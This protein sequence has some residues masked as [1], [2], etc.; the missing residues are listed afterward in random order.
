ML[1]NDHLMSNAADATAKGFW[2][3]NIESFTVAVVMALIIK[4]FA[5]EAFEVPTESM[6]PT[7]IGRSPGGD[8]L[9]VDKFDG[10]AREPERFE[11]RVFMYPLSQ[12][13]NYVKRLI[14]IG[15]ETV[16]VAHGDIFTGESPA[17]PFHIARKS[18][19]I[20]EAIFHANP[21][22]PRDAWTDFGGGRIWNTW[23]RPAAGAGLN[24][25]GHLRLDAG[26]SEL[27]VGLSKGVTPERKDPAAAT[28][29][30]HADADVRLPQGDLRFH[31]DVTPAAGA[32]SVVLRITDGTQVTTPIR[33]DLAVEGSGGTSRL[34]HG[35]RVIESA[36]LKACQLKPA[37]RQ[38][39][40]LEN[41][42]DRIRVLLDGDEL[43][44]DLYEQSVIPL[45][46]GE[47]LVAFGLTRGV[48]EFSELGLERDIYTTQFEGSPNTFEIP[49]D[50]YLL[51]G[52]N[53]ANSLDARAFRMVGLRMRATGEVLLGDL[54]AVSDDFAAPRQD[55]NPW[56]EPGDEQRADAP[57]H[58]V[59][60]AGNHRRLSAGSYDILDLNH[61]ENAGGV[62]LM[63]LHGQ[64]I[65]TP[66][67]AQ[68][69]HRA[70]DTA[71]LAMLTA[72]SPHAFRAQSRL[73]H[74][75][76]RQ[77]MLGR[78]GFTFLP[79]G[80]NLIKALFSFGDFRIIR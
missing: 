22:I 48:A 72:H 78:A 64:S 65:G 59:D 28:R 39:I 21:A 38:R 46:G 79:A 74:Y 32:G 56:I 67:D 17:G 75:V 53:S 52:D 71:T 60:I 12:R 63:A 73:M 14:G 4:Q 42:D 36:Q 19:D 62:G 50:H 10:L 30:G 31:V 41:V 25:E 58:F 55:N 76:P 54:E 45:A 26:A 24:A 3:S 6:E 2:R 9:I 8:R 69:A 7:I 43:V 61:F 66:R 1:E 23:Q 57:H 13:V 20:Q 37:V 70:M 47:S 15:P 77:F 5:F 16:K 29:K 51:L 40:T 33:L 18:E 49:A 34:M 44:R 27:L 35:S 68:L 80:E 11:V